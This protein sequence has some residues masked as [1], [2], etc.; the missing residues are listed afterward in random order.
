MPADEDEVLDSDRE[1][2]EDSRDFVTG[3]NQHPRKGWSSSLVVLRSKSF[4]LYCD[5]TD[6]L[7]SGDKPYTNL[8]CHAARV[9]HLFLYSGPTA[10]EPE[11][12]S[13]LSTME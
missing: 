6:Y 5:R 9:P 13:I 3:L 1:Q 8:T 11:A 12:E 7:S 2:L 4:S 10:R